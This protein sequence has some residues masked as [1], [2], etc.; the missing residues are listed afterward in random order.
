MTPSESDGD[1]SDKS[2]LLD[3][4]DVF[5]GLQLG[6]VKSS[7]VAVDAAT[8]P[9]PSS[10]PTGNVFSCCVLQCILVRVVG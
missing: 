6:G 2:A 10:P 3:K 9:P 4:S 7:G 8:M 5:S 1:K